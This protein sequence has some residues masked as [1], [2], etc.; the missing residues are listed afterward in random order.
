MGIQGCSFGGIQTNY[1]VTH[2]NIFAAAYTASGVADFISHYGSLASG[3][4]S[5]QGVYELGQMRMGASLWQIPELYI[6]NSP[7]FEVDKVTTPLLIMHT[8]NDGIC[9]FA[10]AMEFFT[11]LRR[12]GKKVW[13]LQYN[14]CDH[15]LWGKSADDLNNRL[16]Q[17]FDHYLKSAPSP[18][19]MIQGKPIE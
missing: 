19:W 17:F 7:I 12:L 2:T 8:T 4:E 6:K 16:T 11:G 1:L 3:G 5:V 10:N 9:S 13:L 18:N 14:E 15:G